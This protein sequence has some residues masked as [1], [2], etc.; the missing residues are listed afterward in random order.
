M[1]NRSTD[2]ERQLASRARE[3]LAFVG[4]KQYHED[5]AKSIPLRVKKRL[6][7]ARA[8]ATR[9]Q[10]VLL[11]EPAA[12]MNPQETIGL[13]ALFERIRKEGTATLP[14]EQNDYLALEMADTAY[15]LETGR[16]AVQGTG[17]ELLNNDE[18]RKA[19]LGG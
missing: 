19:N 17:R 5:L 14:V 15:V 7:A 3:L 9:A 18:V 1:S 11:D 2:E 4:L 10:L 16:V 12:G 6:K 13:V 8:L